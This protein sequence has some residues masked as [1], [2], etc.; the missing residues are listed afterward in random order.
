MSKMKDILEEWLFRD[1]DVRG[2]VTSYSGSGDNINLEA[3]ARITVD[4]FKEEELKELE[5]LSQG[6][7]SVEDI[8]ELF[9]RALLNKM[10][11]VIKETEISG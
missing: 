7:I 11:E 6:K 5:E 8:K 9:Y 1:L 10:R 2:L 3:L 4:G